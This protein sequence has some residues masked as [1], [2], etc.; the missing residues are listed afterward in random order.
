MMRKKGLMIALVVILSLGMARVT[1]AADPIKVGTLM[2]LTGP[3]PPL[4]RTCCSACKWRSMTS[5]RA[6]DCWEEKI[7]I[8]SIDDAA[9]RPSQCQPSP[10]S[11]IRTKWI[12]L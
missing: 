2:A 1:I 8:I 6:G 11:S 3:G 5:M 7:E 10:G 4:A 12:S 9:S